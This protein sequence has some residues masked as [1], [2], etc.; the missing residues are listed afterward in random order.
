[1]KP[2][3]QVQ[4][5]GGRLKRSGS[6]LLSPGTVDQTRRPPQAPDPN[7][8]LEPQDEA[9]LIRV[10]R[11]RKCPGKVLAHYLVDENG[12]AGGWG[13]GAIGECGRP[14]RCCD[15]LIGLADED[16]ALVWCPVAGAA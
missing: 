9:L 7:F 6:V 3:P 5:D 15:K 13:G 10:E 16:L 8:T 12:F 4:G 11:C 14:D 1:M 2:P